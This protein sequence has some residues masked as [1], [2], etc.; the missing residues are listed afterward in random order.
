VQSAGEEVGDFAHIW[1]NGVQHASGG[2]GYNVVAMTR[3]G[4]ILAHASFDTMLTTQSTRMA[5]WLNGWPEGTIVIGAVEDSAATEDGKAWDE[6]LRPALERLG[7]TGDLRGK[8]RWSHAFVGV[9]GAP[10]G[11]AWE[12]VALTMPAT[13]WL[14]VP[15]PAAVGY[16]PLQ[17][18]TLVRD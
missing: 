12:E 17:S 15:L 16:G 18:M 8:L 6:V 13:V 7:V 2:R 14:G 4:H 10:P 5:E 3:E 9:V 1:I 11:S